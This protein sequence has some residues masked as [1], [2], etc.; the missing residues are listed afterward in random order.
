MKTLRIVLVPGE[1]IEAVKCPICLVVVP[2]SQVLLA[3]SG[4]ELFSGVKV[5]CGGVGH[6]EIDGVAVGGVVVD[7]GGTADDGDG[8]GEVGEDSG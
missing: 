5:L 6:L 7:L 3:D 8:S 2:C 4:V 1:R